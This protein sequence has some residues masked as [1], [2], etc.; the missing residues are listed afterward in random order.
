MLHRQQVNEMVRWI[1]GVE[2]RCLL[3]MLSVIPMLLHISRSIF[4]QTNCLSYMDLI[5]L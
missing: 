2:G 1:G 4:T 3:E 5:M